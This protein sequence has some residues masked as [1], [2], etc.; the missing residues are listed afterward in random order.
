[1][2]LEK[3]QFSSELTVFQL[4]AARAALRLSLSDVAKIAGLRIATIQKLES[5]DIYS[6]P[7]SSILTIS[8][9][10]SVLENHGVEFYKNNLVR[11]VPL[12]EKFTIR[13]IS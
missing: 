12:D 10:R 6:F 8:K 3:I 4:R 9:V 1:M 7:K 2:K 11:L 5:G 13:F